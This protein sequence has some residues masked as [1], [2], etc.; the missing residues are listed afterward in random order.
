MTYLLHQWNFFG[1]FIS[2]PPAPFFLSV[3][4]NDESYNFIKLLCFTNILSSNRIF[5]KIN[6]I[7][8]RSIVTFLLFV[9][10]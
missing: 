8:V 2:P 7:A 9:T 10:I 5:I 4:M 1:D 6:L 3:S